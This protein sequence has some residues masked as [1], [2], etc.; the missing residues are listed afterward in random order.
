[1]IEIPGLDPGPEP[2]DP[3]IGGSVGE[4]IGDDVPPG[5]FLQAVVSDGA[6]GAQIDIRH[7][8]TDAAHWYKPNPTPLEKGG[9]GDWKKLER[10]PGRAAISR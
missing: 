2:P 3:L 10:E 8:W 5:L 6:G 4:R 1:M 7:V 9:K